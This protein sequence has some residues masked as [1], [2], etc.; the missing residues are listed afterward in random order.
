MMYYPD[1]GR[2]L[3]QVTCCGF[4]A[5]GTTRVCDKLQQLLG[6]RQTLETLST[7]NHGRKHVAIMYAQALRASV[8]LS[9]DVQT[10]CGRWY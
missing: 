1:S 10:R 5:Y 3:D 2:R 6:R 7:N 8:N 9:S 4:S